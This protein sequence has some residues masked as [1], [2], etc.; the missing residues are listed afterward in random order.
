MKSKHALL[1]KWRSMIWVRVSGCLLKKQMDYTVPDDCGDQGDRENS[2]RVDDHK[3]RIVSFKAASAEAA[4]WLDDD[5]RD[6]GTREPS[7]L[8]HLIVLARV[9]LR[10]GDRRIV[11]QRRLVSQLQSCGFSIVM[12]AVAVIVARGIVGLLGV[13]PP[14]AAGQREQKDDGAFLHVGAPC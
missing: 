2:R 5:E 10:V 6:H 7:A 1:E 13:I 12:P 4:V 11:L 9:E 8:L 3:R 14:A